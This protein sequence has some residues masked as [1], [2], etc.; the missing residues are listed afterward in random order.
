M[1]GVRRS[2]PLSWLKPRGIPRSPRMNPGGV[3]SVVTIC[4]NIYE[5]QR[6]VAAGTSLSLGSAITAPDM[7]TSIVTEN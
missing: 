1:D 4:G 5:F 6:S 3:E 2:R 7:F